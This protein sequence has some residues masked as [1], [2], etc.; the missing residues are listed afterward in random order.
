MGCGSH[1]VLQHKNDKGDW[2]DV[3]IDCLHLSSS[4]AR[5]FNDL[6]RSVNGVH[7]GFPDDFKFKRTMIDD[8]WNEYDVSGMSDKRIKDLQ[9]HLGVKFS[10]DTRHYK[11][12]YLGE[13]SFYWIDCYQF[14]EQDFDRAPRVCVETDN[15]HEVILTVT[16]GTEWDGESVAL[17]LQKFFNMMLSDYNLNNYRMILGFDS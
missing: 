17:D 9:D 4:V 12:Y 8:N 3:L 6:L 5:D 7:S 14:N 2:E 1:A 15:E 16:N 13:H 11:D 10:G